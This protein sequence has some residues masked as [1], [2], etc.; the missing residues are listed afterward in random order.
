MGRWK[1]KTP[2]WRLP[3]RLGSGVV[4]PEASARYTRAMT[5]RK[6][7]PLAALGCFAAMLAATWRY[8]VTGGPLIAR[9]GPFGGIL[10]FAATLGVMLIIVLWRPRKPAVS[11][12]APGWLPEKSVEDVELELRRES[13]YD[14]RK[15][16]TA[17]AQAASSFTGKTNF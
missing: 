9:V 14:E 11:A 2:R 1:P 4:C 15:R 16:R 12:R 3:P 7:I 8:G 10:V 17:E 6:L 13:A 5:W